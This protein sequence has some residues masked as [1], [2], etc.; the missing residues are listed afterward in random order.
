MKETEEIDSNER[1]PATLS[2]ILYL[3]AAIL[4][5]FISMIMASVLVRIHPWFAAFEFVAIVLL[6][7]TAQ[8]LGRAG[9]RLAMVLSAAATGI[10][11]FWLFA[12]VQ[13]FYIRG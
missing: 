3:A 11:M 4:A 12:A 7:V 8:K 1:K 5:F 6:Y 2:D 9:N 10:V 13:Y